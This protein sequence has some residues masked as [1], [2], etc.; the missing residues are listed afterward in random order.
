[1]K[2]RKLQYRLEDWWDDWGDVLLDTLKSMGRLILVLLILFAIWMGFNQL[3]KP[4]LQRAERW[5]EADEP[6]QALAT[7]DSVPPQWWWHPERRARYGLLRSKALDKSYTDVRDDSLL[8][9][10]VNYYHIFGP[11]RYAMESLYY[12]GRTHQNAGRIPE[13][14]AYFTL[15]DRLADSLGEYHMGGLIARSISE[16]HNFMKDFPAQL[17]YAEKA[18]D[19]FYRAGSSYHADYM[20]YDLGKSLYLNNKYPESMTHYKKFI[21]VCIKNNDLYSIRAA[22]IGLASVELSQGE[23]KEAKYHFEQAHE[24]YHCPQNVEWLVQYASSCAGVGEIDKALYYIG[25]ADE[26]AER[27]VEYAAIL[28]RNNDINAF[29]ICSLEGKSTVGHRLRSEESLLRYIYEV[30]IVADSLKHFVVKSRSL[31]HKL[32]RKNDLICFI[33][34]IVILTSLA[35]SGLFMWRKSQYKRAIEN[36]MTQLMTVRNNL[37]EKESELKEL[38][39]MVS[40]QFKERFDSINHLSE[41]YYL[42]QNSAKEKDK[43]Y[44]EVQKAIRQLGEESYVLKNL[45]PLINA[46]CNRILERMREQLPDFRGHD[47][48]LYTYLCC[49]FSYQA[50]SLFL[51]TSSS[52]LYSRVSRMRER[53]RKSGVPDCEEFERMI[54]RK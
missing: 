31:S 45:E 29:R 30:P 23:Y 10:A 33:L 35:L 5:C 28:L 40:S 41:I 46:R 9:L 24:V 21:D 22:Y 2:W 20:H 43:I 32:E 26:I 38:G 17:Y 16:V 12:T 19:Y 36:Y 42:H 8:R 1:M 3:M 27:G 7:L 44:Q 6:A 54:P 50:I 25:K 53:I 15:A 11:D 48:Q 39:S 4:E 13:A 34:I 51:Q 49:G 14:Y 52:I 47:F 18:Y 37:L